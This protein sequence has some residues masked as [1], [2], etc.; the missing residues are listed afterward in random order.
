MSKV[1]NSCSAPISWDPKQREKLGIKGPL[2]Q[3]GLTPHR[4][5]S[6]HKEPAA[7]EPSTQV[8]DPVLIAVLGQLADSIKLLALSNVANTEQQREEVRHKVLIA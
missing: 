6:I 7:S 5:Y 1:C 3:D 4:C 8:T 2:N